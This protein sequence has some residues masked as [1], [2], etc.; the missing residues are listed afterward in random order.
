MELFRYIKVLIGINIQGI[1]RLVL[2]GNNLLQQ[3]TQAT[4]V[5]APE[6]TLRAKNHS[7]SHWSQRSPCRITGPNA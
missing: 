1:D 2:C 3:L 7:I 5:C 6:K 4:S